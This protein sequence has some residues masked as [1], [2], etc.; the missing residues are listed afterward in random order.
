MTRRQN[1]SVT[2]GRGTVF[3][4][5]T[6]LDDSPAVHIHQSSYEPSEEVS[7]L[8]DA[9][10]YLTP[11]EALKVAHALLGHLMDPSM[12]DDGVTLILRGYVDLT[13]YTGQGQAT[14]FVKTINEG[15]DP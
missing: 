9:N 1:R 12:G 4:G 6:D 2:L 3:V 14:D 8:S 13:V 11:T 7:A 10:I 5:D 15:D